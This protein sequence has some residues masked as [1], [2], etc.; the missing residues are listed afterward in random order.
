MPDAVD[1]HM[2]LDQELD[3]LS[4]PETGVIGSIGFVGLGA[5][6]GLVPAFSD[7]MGNVNADRLEPLTGGE[8]ATLLILPGSFMLAVVCLVIFAISVCRDKALTGVIKARKKQSMP[9]SSSA[10]GSIAPSA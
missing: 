8:I 9:A 3:Q 1:W 10:A 5:A 2:I 7:V 6:I 4:R